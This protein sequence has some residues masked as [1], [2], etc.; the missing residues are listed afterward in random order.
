MEWFVTMN[1][2]LWDIIQEGYKPPPKLFDGVK[3]PKPI[4]EWKT[5]KRRER[6]MLR[7]FYF[8]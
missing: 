5:K 3:V 1:D 7:L 4:S 8:T 6:L 2:D